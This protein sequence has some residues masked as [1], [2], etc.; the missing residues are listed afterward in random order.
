MRSEQPLTGFCLASTSFSLRRLFLLVL[1]CALGCW[2]AI[3]IRWLG[4]RRQVIEG[5]GGFST[6]TNTVYP[7]PRAPSLLWLF[8]EPGYERLTIKF[9]GPMPG[10]GLS[11]NQ[12]DELTRI[13]RLFPEAKEVDGLVW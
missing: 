11:A 6:D 9:D 12:Q 3:E 5:R 1:L 10:A 13:R 8:G 2:F 7:G 4:Q